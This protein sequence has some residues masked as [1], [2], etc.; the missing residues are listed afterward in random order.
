M[1]VPDLLGCGKS[2]KPEDP[3]AY[4]PSLMS[5]DYIAI[6][7]Q[8]CIDKAIVIGHDLC[9]FCIWPCGE[10]EYAHD[11]FVNV[12]ER[13]VHRGLRIYTLNDS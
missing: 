13:R 1:I 2:S 8:E 12:A 10:L 6:L 7:D 3:A 9:G 4:K 11:H 5:R